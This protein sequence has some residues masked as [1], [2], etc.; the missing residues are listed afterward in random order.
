MSKIIEPSPIA[1]V[2]N[3]AF[4]AVLLWHFG[5]G[6]Q[7]SR[8][9][10]L[11]TMIG[12]FLILPLI[13]HNPTLS[14]IRSTYSSS[15]LVKLV[16]KLAESREN[17]VSIHTR[18]LA[19]RAL[20]LDSIAVGITSRLLSVDYD[21]GFVRANDVKTPAISDRL[22]YHAAGANKLGIWFSRLPPSQVFSMLQVEI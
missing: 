12:Y 1:L 11:P 19:L 8:V 18:A 17:L 21:S 4:G 2:Q 10:E 5:R 22:K 13:L 9:G 15:G 7:Q 6:F 20:T 3:P 16:S 14:H